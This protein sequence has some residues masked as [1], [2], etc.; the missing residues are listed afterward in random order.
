MQ[1]TIN[2]TWGKWLDADNWDVFAT[3]N[4]GSLHLLEGN[5]ID[6]SAKIW[7]SCLSTV[8]RALYGAT[9][10]A[11]PRFN[12]V[13]FKHYG[14]SGKNP[15]IHILAKAPINTDAFCIA[16]NAI[17][18]TQFDPTANP[19]SN[20]IAPLITAKGA[21]SYSQHEEFKDNTGAFDE[22]LSY[23]NLG[24][25]HLVREDALQRLHSKTAG[26]RLAQARLALPI[27]IKTTQ[28]NFEKREKREKRERRERMRVAA[29]RRN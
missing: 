12:R 27:H 9:R 11:Q 1:K 28:E 29:L 17:W 20:S 21:T 10:K 24:D 23:I 3:L 22:R 4:F 26:I 16:L 2:T 8:D 14:D 18:A 19:I 25:P 5:K 15:H 13:V 7:R 6:S